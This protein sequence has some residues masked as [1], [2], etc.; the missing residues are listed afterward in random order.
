MKNKTQKKT[1]RIT[2]VFLEPHIRCSIEKLAKEQKRTI[3]NMASI[4]I[5]FGLKNFRGL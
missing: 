2:S 3:S 1:P 5:E 4:L